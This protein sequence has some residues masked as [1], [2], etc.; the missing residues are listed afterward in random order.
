MISMIPSIAVAVSVGREGLNTLLVAS[1][2]ALS[3]IL[4]FVVFPYVAPVR[5][6][7][8]PL[9]TVATASS[10]SPPTPA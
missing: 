6:R 4:P 10:A 5:D 2:V 9:L 8:V 7:E 3:I 1:Q